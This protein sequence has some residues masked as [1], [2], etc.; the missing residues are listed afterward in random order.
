M[1]KHPCISKSMCLYMCQS[2]QRK[3]RVCAKLRHILFMSIQLGIKSIK[4]QIGSVDR[5]TTLNKM[6]AYQI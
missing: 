4:S 3:R 5:V 1:V 6:Q 2:S